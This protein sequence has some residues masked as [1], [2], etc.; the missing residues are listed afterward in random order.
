MDD[1]HSKHSRRSNVHVRV[2]VS[3]TYNNRNS[4][5]KSRYATHR[6]IT[7]IVLL[8]LAIAINGTGVSAQTDSATTSDS[9]S[10]AKA[11]SLQNAGA[12]KRTQAKDL[13]R[14]KRALVIKV[15][16]EVD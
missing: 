4:P 1:H 5:M 10:Q 12:I 14:V 6:Q 9:T 7:G 11:Q 8:L 3:N 13:S 15:E 2:A 16:D